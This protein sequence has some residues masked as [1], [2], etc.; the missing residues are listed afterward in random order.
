[1]SREAQ[2]DQPGLGQL[3][4]AVAEVA[5]R[6]RTETASLRSDC[7]AG[8]TVAVGGVPDAMAG[9]VLA[10]VNPMLGLYAN[11][12]GPV[13]G[14]LLASSALMVVMDTSASALVAG[15]SL[16]TLDAGQRESLLALMVIVAG[17][18]QIVFGVLRM[19]RITRFVSYS[20]MTGFLAGV[21]VVLML[22]QL[23]VLAGVD[24]SGDNKVTQTF[25]LVEQVEHVSIGSVIVAAVTITTALLLSRTGLRKFSSLVAIAVATVVATVAGMD[26]VELVRDLG[27]IARGI[28]MPSLPPFVPFLD[29]LTG[30]FSVA[31]VVLVQ[32]AGVGQSVPNRD[33]SRASASR[34]FIAQ[35]AANVVVGFFRGI[36]VGGS[37]GATAL[38]VAGGARSRWAAV[39]SGLW[40]AVIVIGFPGVITRV[41]LPSLG[42][43]LILAALA[44]IK[45]SDI[46][47]V[48]RAGWPSR[49]VVV[50]TFLATLLLPI[51]G[52]VGLGVVLSAL[53]YLNESSAD[54]SVVELRRRSDGRIEEHKAPRS[55]ASNDVTVLDVYGPLFFAGARTLERLLPSARGAERPAVVIRLR[56]QTDVGAT[57][58]SVLTRYAETVRAAG[59]HLY[60]TGI[61]TEGHHHFTSGG[62][63]RDTG[64]LRV[65]NATPVI[66][67]STTRAA[68][69][70]REWLSTAS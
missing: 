34:N 8:L 13:V 57:L 26:D 70:A 64:P 38:N 2:V 65:Y 54:I 19:G 62:M 24:V 25:D 30:A 20:V 14:G 36:P 16:R 43:V 48:W 67:E 59:G 5:E 12:V 1:M 66:G 11:M 35:G 33:G 31:L 40:T 27:E 23:P 15:Q 4:A 17:V 44:A 58:V 9:G 29:I 50:T 47:S 18:I 49:L 55:L 51:Q 45:P 60:L 41:A 63:F 61:R 42:A 37:V 28:P 22:S 21:S 39:F 56:G 32:G 3:R 52:A 53:L 68:A 69:D 46:A 7:V 10:G 6:A